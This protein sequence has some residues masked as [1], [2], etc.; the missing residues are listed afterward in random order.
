[1][2][3]RN[4]A[5]VSTPGFDGCHCISRTARRYRS[6]AAKVT[7]FSFTS[8]CTPVRVG[9]E[10]SRPAAIATWATA[11]AKVSLVITPVLSGSSGKFGYSFI[12][13]VGKVNFALPEVTKT[14]VPSKVIVIG[15]FGS[16]LVISTNNFPG[17][18]TFPASIIWA[19]KLALLDVS[20]SEPESSTFEP[21][22]SITI[23]S[24]S[25]LIGRV[26]KLRETQ[27]TQS[28]S[29]LCSTM[30]FIWLAFPL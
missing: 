26:D 25:V 13:S 5:V 29:A 14:R 28:A 30:N 15:L 11:A 18:K 12:E 19:A 20:K 23:P 8:T 22:A 24:S 9:S 10:S 21:V 27:L 4:K 7:V 16:D 3:A 2:R 1:M 17:T 6:V